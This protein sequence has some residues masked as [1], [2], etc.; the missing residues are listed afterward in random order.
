MMRFTLDLFPDLPEDATPEQ[1]LEWAL[2]TIKSNP[3]LAW[4]IVDGD[5]NVVHKDVVLSTPMPPAFSVITDEDGDHHVQCPH[6]GSLGSIVEVDQA[7]RF[8]EL[9]FDKGPMD[10]LGDMGGTGDWDYDHWFCTACM[11]DDLQA[12]VGFAIREWV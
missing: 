3:G 1:K 2:S 4:D 5:A 10:P 8:N 9:V 11:S 6:C 12:P 7:I